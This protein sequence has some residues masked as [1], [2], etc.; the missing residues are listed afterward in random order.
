[1]PSYDEWGQAIVDYFSNSLAQGEALY[2]R[3]DTQTLEEIGQ[4]AHWQYKKPV[5]GQNWSEDFIFAVRGYMVQHDKV[6]M[7]WIYRNHKSLNVLKPPKELPWLAFQVLA[8]SRM[9]G[10][11]SSRMSNYYK[12]LR[13]LLEL[14]GEGRPKGLEYKAWEALWQRWNRWVS[15]RDWEPTATRHTQ[16]IDYPIL[17]CLLRDGEGDQIQRLWHQKKMPAD[18]NRSQLRQWFNGRALYQVNKRLHKQLHSGQPPELFDLLYNLYLD[19]AW[20]EAEPGA[21]RVRPSVEAGLYRAE[22]SHNDTVNYWLYPRQR[23]SMRTE[24]LAVR[25]PQG[26]VQE[27]RL[28]RPGWFEPLAY[29][30]H[31]PGENL[32]LN[33]VAPEGYQRLIF[34]GSPIWAL[35]EDP[36][37][38]DSYA[39]WR[40]PEPGESFILLCHESLQYKIKRMVRQELLSFDEGKNDEDSG[41][42]PHWL[43]YY[44]CQ[45]LSSDPEA[46]QR[47]QAEAPEI[48]ELLYPKTGL[49][50]STHGGL[51]VRSQ[52]GLAG[53]L[54]DYAPQIQVQSSSSDL[55]NTRL[56]VWQIHDNDKETLCWE[57]RVDSAGP[58]KLFWEG[59]GQYR[60][61]VELANGAESAK[62][63]RLLD[64]HELSLPLPSKTFAYEMENKML[65]R[66]G[67]LYDV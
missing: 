58:H 6:D 62:Q 61:S 26:E 36:D 45:I 47:L 34:R 54:A 40:R 42:P 28:Q 64:W 65:M 10:D 33:I 22:N 59:P 51:R 50:L 66:G 20:Q 9:R 23:A 1:M 53:W 44:D 56:Q 16:Y 29:D 67:L 2:L 41:L 32:N 46:W 38:P 14:P 12:Q 30:L 49:H 7:E 57:G 35:V 5:N 21:K 25:D 60:V 15:A 17:Q 52:E 11:G 39:T 3:T 37:Q 48:W 43:E 8:A 24:R 27:L 63:I 31:D 18:L 55:N 13:A 19:G 4:L